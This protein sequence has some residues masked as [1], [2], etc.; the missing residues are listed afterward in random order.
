MKE[1][2]N[3]RNRSRVQGFRSSSNNRYERSCVTRI[4]NMSLHD[5]YS[6]LLECLKKAFGKRLKTVVL[7]GSR[8]RGKV[9]ADRDHDIFLVI[10]N[11]SDKPLERQ[12]EVRTAIWDVPIT[13]INTIAK[14]PK[15]VDINLTPLLLEICV[16]GV[17]LF[18]ESY[19]EPYRKKA[20]N[21]LSQS[22]LK[23]KRV[24]GEWYWQ[25][26]RIPDKEWE[27]SWEGFRELQ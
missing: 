24:G 1:G 12:K 16:D 4:V 23:R 10:E 2:I 3:K 9:K 22:G 7:F 19:F 21:A 13:R 6:L 15:E 8:A 18:G 14:T 20:L 17:C 5:S 27:L 25:F 26:E 11:L